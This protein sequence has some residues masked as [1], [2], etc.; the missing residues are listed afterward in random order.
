MEIVSSLEN[1]MDLYIYKAILANYLIQIKLVPS[2]Q[3]YDEAQNTESIT[4]YPKNGL[5]LI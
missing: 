4:I 1:K 2:L 3:N 5:D